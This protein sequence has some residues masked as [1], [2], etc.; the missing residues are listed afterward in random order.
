MNHWDWSLIQTF[1]RVAETG[2][3][4][5]AA[6]ALGKSQPTASRDV[7]ALEDAIGARL[8]VRHSRGLAL[9]DRGA[10]LFSSAKVLDESVE[11]LFRR[12]TGTRDVPKGSVRITVN[13]PLG[14]HVLQPCFAAL[15]RDFP[16]VAIELVIDNSVANLSRREADI[17]VRMFRPEQLDLVAKKVGAVELGFFA[18]RDY[19]K[20][21]G[22]PTTVDDVTGHTLIGSD[23]DPSWARAIQALG[24]LPEHFAFRTDSIL[25]QIEAI[26]SGVGI[27]GTHLAIAARFPRLVRV[28]PELRVPPLEVWVVMH[29]D[30]RGDSAVKVVYDALSKSLGDY[31]ARASDTGARPEGAREGRP[32]PRPRRRRESGGRS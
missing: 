30:L 8:F 11:G 17:A 27:G 21:H 4:T 14:V 18:S 5:A 16:G 10:E 19:L 25:A 1:V 15:R 13:E 6:K 12:A 23:R 24:L 26:A 32:H 31:A 9:S 7:Q 2:S 20:R 29:Q 3:L 28:L 22:V